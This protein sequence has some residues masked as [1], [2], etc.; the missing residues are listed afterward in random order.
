MR[1][2]SFPAPLCHS[3]LNVTHKREKRHTPTV[4][5]CELMVVNSEDEGK[6]YLFNVWKLLPPIDLARTS[7]ALQIVS[8]RGVPP[9]PSAT[10]V[11]ALS[12]T[13]ASQHAE[14]YIKA[15]STHPQVTEPAAKKIPGSS[16]TRYH[17]LNQRAEQYV[18][19]LPQALKKMP[20]ADFV[21]RHAFTSL[22]PTGAGGEA[23]RRATVWLMS[24][25]V[26]IAANELLDISEDAKADTYNKA[27]ERISCSTVKSVLHEH[28]V[29]LRFMS[30]VYKS[31]VDQIETRARDEKKKIQALTPPFH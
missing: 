21:S 7:T 29:N 25:Q 17:F 14:Q 4:G 2:V 19:F 16:L 15:A 9:P 12:D 3:F 26:P 27:N 30:A 13:I 31:L 20:S 23:S 5:H 6:L 22:D 18:L 8:P 28:G 11:I 10:A 1:S 24:K